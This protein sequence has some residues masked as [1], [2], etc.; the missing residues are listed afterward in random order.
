MAT[1]PITSPYNFVP[2]S[3]DVVTPEWGKARGMNSHAL[4]HDAPLE[5]GLS[6]SL[7]I[8]LTNDTPLLIASD[9]DAKGEKTPLKQGVRFVIPGS[10]LR[11][12][13][14]NVVEIATYSKLGPGMQDRKLF[15]RDLTK[16]GKWYQDR[17]VSSPTAT[18]TKSKPGWLRLEDQENNG[19]LMYFIEPTVMERVPVKEALD[20][21]GNDPLG[22]EVTYVM[23]GK[24]YI[25]VRTG[26]VHGK[27][28][29]FGFRSTCCADKMA[30]TDTV[31]QS[32]VAAHQYNVAWW[33]QDGN[34][35]KPGYL[36]AKL[37]RNERIPVF[38][39]VGVDKKIS[40]IGLALMFRIAY[41]H[42]LVD[43][44]SHTS[45]KH[46]DDPTDFDFAQA[47][48]GALPGDSPDDG[49][50]SRVSFGALFSIKGELQRA[51]D[52]V[53]LNSPKPSFYPAYLKQNPNGELN[54][55]E[56][57]RPKLAGWKRYQIR[58]EKDIDPTSNGTNNA[59]SSKLRPLEKG[60][61]FKGVIRFHNLRPAELGA[62]VWAL[63]WGGDD[64]LRHSL[65]MG[66]PYGYGSVAVE[67]S[68]AHITHNS[69]PNQDI[70]LENAPLA[71]EA[72]LKFTVDALT[73]EMTE[74]GRVGNWPDTPELN[75]LR[76]MANPAV[77]DI[78]KK[79]DQ[80]RYPI[81]KTTRFPKNEFKDI[82]NDK[83]RL[84]KP[85]TGKS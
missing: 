56:A 58:S 83:R 57:A 81:L 32:F 53:V 72:G 48:F 77:G 63:T 3:P 1:T 66:K 40:A 45:I 68:G 69:D 67:I 10:S 46:L 55:L 18:E 23:E 62:L 25:V 35:D 26:A 21:M 12:M 13:L 74:K 59:V 17:M 70:H 16:S 44:L 39:T 6:G 36:H 34:F 60:A 19:K 42:S 29:D 4:S 2:L 15:A 38:Y 47:L 9:P 22:T 80:L 41:K 82:K 73:Q 78:A 84:V 65:G 37:R 27:V 7:D 54:T 76:A 33:V 5:N 31:F 61:V 85:S 43:A 14:R 52:H 8:T 24:D 79:N 11:G 75:E 20:L 28:N 64:K 50:S 49:L 30:V 51:P 71:T